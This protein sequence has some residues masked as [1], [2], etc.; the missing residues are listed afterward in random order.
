[1]QPSYYKYDLSIIMP[2]IRTERWADVYRSIEKS[3]SGNWEL[4]IISE[5][6]LPDEVK[7][8]ALERSNIKLI[9]SSRAPM[10]KQQQALSHIQG[11]YVTVMSDDSL[12]HPGTLDQSIAFIKTLPKDT[13]VVLKY[14]EGNETEFPGWYHDQK[15]EHRIF[16]TNYDFMR[17]DLYYFSDTHLSS[18]MKGIPNHSPILSCALYP[19]EMLIDSGGW[20]SR[21]QSQ[22]MG[23][24]D[25]SARLMKLGYKYLIQ[26]LVVS[27]CGYMEQDTGDHGPIH[28]AQL[29]DDETLLHKLWDEQNDRGKIFMDNWKKTAEVWWRKN[30]NVDLTVICPGIRTKNWVVL[31]ESIKKSFSG[32]FEL[33]FV[34]PYYPPDELMGIPHVRFVKEWRTPISCQQIGLLRAMGKYITWAAD[35]GVYL[36]GA[37]DIGMAKLKDKPVKALVMGKYIEGA[38]NTYMPMSENKYYN[39]KNHA[40]S[41][42][43]HLPNECYWMLNVGIV[44]TELLKDVGGWDAE[45]F[46]VCPMAYNDLAVRL[47]NY[48]VEFIIQD[49]VMYTCSHM[50]GHMGDHGPIHDGQVEHDQPIFERIYSSINSAKR[51]KIDINNWTL[52]PDRWERRFGKAQ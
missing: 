23:N 14:L 7:E 11:E 6:S 44:P 19:V 40:A 3:F 27:S 29:E 2:A 47:Q 36:P 9:E 52:L 42:L 46:E 1:M 25:L 32:T 34:G 10:Q 48:G 22:A 45:N 15:P 5:K 49:E 31:Y 13:L 28:F 37:L 20:D 43:R 26:D 39:L 12:W 35:D 21:F 18:S 17:H 30:M 4:I 8:L 41:T 38:D 24:V 50:P 33:I 51:I 16:K